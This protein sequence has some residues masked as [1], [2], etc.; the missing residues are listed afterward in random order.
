MDMSKFN[1]FV[2]DSDGS[3]IVYNTLQG[4]ISIVNSNLA[5]I[6]K[7][8]DIKLLE[9]SESPDLLENL[10]EQGIIKDSNFDELEHYEKMHK[11]WKEGK[12]NVEFNVLLTYDCNFE[13]P[14]C[15]QGRGDVGEKIHGFRYMNQALL[16][17]VKKFI[18]NT[19]IERGSKKLELVLYGGEPFLPLAK[20]MGIDLTD[21]I[22][23]WTKANNIN[24]GLNVL[25]NG[26]LMDEETIR[27]LSK[28]KA[29]LQIPIDGD[30]EMHNKYRFYK[31]DGR[32]SFEDIAKVL[33]M[34]RGT[35][36][37]T[38]IRISL[39]DQTYP[40]ME[41]LLDELKTRKLTHV[42]PDFC[43]ITAFTEACVGF[44]GHTLSDLKLFKIIPE[45]W[46]KAHERGFPLDIRPQVKP[47]PCSSIADGS[48]I[49]DP[50]G[51]V[52]KCWEL[53]GL[54]DNIVGRIDSNGNLMK[55]SAYEDVLKRNPLE[56]EQCRN[57]VYLPSCAG[58]CV[59]KAKWQSKT[60]RAPGCGTE[61]YLLND[62]IK[63]YVKTIDLSK[64]R[65]IN[66][67]GLSLLKVEGRQEPKMSHCYVLV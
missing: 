40:T 21:E 66:S 67:H 22:Y 6:L 3:F 49:V 10:K 51:D 54:K 53:V 64:L 58:G 1:I 18:K 45:L 16:D 57:H 5:R 9:N 30:P 52:Y 44:G 34:T 13:C 55:T 60:Y 63:T 4:S 26:S 48:F 19:T 38:H 17:S 27:W 28:Y 61:R 25:S 32:G 7:D 33:E 47:L 43:Y 23:E 24:F 2:Q 14:Y 50:F 20:K 15:Y 31:E 62:K 59:C 29:R 11:H 35:D 37:E 46:M 42:Y 65:T 36:I 12:E 8:K 41:R 39:T 56:I